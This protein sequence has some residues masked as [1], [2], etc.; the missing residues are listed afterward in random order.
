[1]KMDVEKDRLHKPSSPERRLRLRKSCKER[2][3][4][5]YILHIYY[6]YR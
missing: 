1:M 4:Y 3:F 2:Y 5:L 6:L